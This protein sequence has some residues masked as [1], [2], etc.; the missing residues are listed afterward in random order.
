[1]T[2]ILISQMKASTLGR[3][4]VKGSSKNSQACRKHLILHKFTQKKTEA[5]GGETKQLMIGQG[6]HSMIEL[7]PETRSPDPPPTPQLPISVSLPLL[8]VALTASQG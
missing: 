7:R 3:S 1:M 5:S 4:A 2:V 6:N 8:S